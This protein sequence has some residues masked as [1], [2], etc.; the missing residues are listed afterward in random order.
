MPSSPP[1]Q[2]EARAGTVYL[3]GAGPGDPGLLTQR[4]VALLSS[5]TEV[6]H[7]YL[8]SD[9][10]LAYCGAQA[11]LVNVGKTGH[12]PQT[13]QDAICEQLVASAR[14]GHRV[15]RLKGGDPLLFGRGAEEALALEAAGIPFEI[16]PGVSSALAVPA[17]A[18]IPV[19]AR[20]LAS[21]VAIVTGH[22]MAGKPSPIPIADTIV[23]LMGV[24]N[25]AVIRDQL[26]AT[27]LDPETPSAVI[28]W[29]TW[30][31]QRV[32]TAA[33]RELPAALSRAG[34]GA[35]AILVIGDV[36]RLRERLSCSAS[37]SEQRCSF[38]AM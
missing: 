6:Y 5:A 4:A 1:F 24:S 18:G 23:V 26:L 35:P 15:V 30:S 16:V 31:R 2:Q 32:V 17:A 38:E 7:D 11:R 28:E 3:V 33:L 8:V 9:G 29:G 34:M 14:S 37:T 10:V 22:S 20:G 21:S 27:G 25:A 36:V 19:T 13:A 12:G